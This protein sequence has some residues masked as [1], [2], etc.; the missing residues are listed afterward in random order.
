L[1]YLK[2]NKKKMQNQINSLPNQQ[3]QITL[4]KDLKPNLK[5]INL[6]VIVLDICKPTQTKDGNEV[7]SVRV[8]DRTGTINLSVWNNYGA[9]LKEGDI[10]KLTGCYTQIWKLSLQLKI[11]TKGALVKCGEFMMVYSEQPDMS[12]LSTG[13]FRF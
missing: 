5:N 13:I 7:R 1:H 4:I 3:Q 9:L 12:L 11:S 2:S 10:I 6:Q 8:A